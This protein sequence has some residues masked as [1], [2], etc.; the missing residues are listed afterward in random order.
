MSYKIQEILADPDKRALWN[1]VEDLKAILL[2]KDEEIARLKEWQNIII[3]SGT[4]QEAVVRMAAAEYAQ[5]AIA[6]W[7]ERVEQLQADLDWVMGEAQYFALHLIY[8]LGACV[9]TREELE[10]N[11][12]IKKARAF[13]SSPLVQSWRVRQGK[14][15][16]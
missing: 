10:A 8:V 4:D 2:S 9:S 1:Q 6:C 16:K 3:G 11:R 12:H 5:T 14:E 7:K 15:S 13:L